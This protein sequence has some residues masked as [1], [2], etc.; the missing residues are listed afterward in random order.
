MKTQ[1]REYGYMIN[2]IPIFSNF[3]SAIAISST[4]TTKVSCCL[5]WNEYTVYKCQ[6]LRFNIPSLKTLIFVKPSTLQIFFLELTLSTTRWLL[7]PWNTIFIWHRML[8]LFY[9]ILHYIA[10]G[11]LIYLTVTRPD[12]A[13]AVHTVSQ[14]M[15]APCINHYVVVMLILRYLKGTL[16]RNLYFSSTSSLILHSNVTD[17][18]FT[19][20]YCFFLGDSFISWPS[21]TARYNTEAKYR[22]LAD[23]SQE[24]IWVRWLLSDMGAPQQSP[25]LLWRANT[26]LKT[27]QLQLIS[28]IDQPTYIFTKAHLPGRFWEFVTNSIWVILPLIEFEGEGC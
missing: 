11:S 16:F 14:F 18:H 27:I 15:T 20:G 9:W 8:V 1:L 12:I 25:T 26:I 5:L 17:R 7:Y 24:L 19:T 6:S 28:T 22:A 21:F 13:Y 4:Y 23:T 2:K 10:M 3:E